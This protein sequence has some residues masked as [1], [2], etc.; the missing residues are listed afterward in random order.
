MKCKNL[1]KNLIANSSYKRILQTDFTNK[2]YKRILETDFKVFF[3]KPVRWER[4][5][6]E[7]AVAPKGRLS[8]AYCYSSF[9]FL[10]LSI[11]FCQTEDLQLRRINEN[12]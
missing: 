1:N 12:K 8:P 3:S 7:M 2:F 10:F 4:H 5:L 9:L 11:Y 6:V